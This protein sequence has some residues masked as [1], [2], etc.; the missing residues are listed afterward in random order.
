MQDRILGVAMLDTPPSPSEPSLV[1]SVIHV[2]EAGQRVVVDRVDLLRADLSQ[3]AS[4]ALSSATLIAVGAFLLAGAWFTL[5][6]AAVVGLQQYLSL[7][8]SLTAV[9][10]VTGGLGAG[11][12]VIGIRLGQIGKVGEVSTSVR[13][14]PDE[15]I[16]TNGALRP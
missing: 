4:R 5:M 13:A 8:A 10:A 15:A 2:L 16:V 11:A 9:A 12:I 3:A 1:E 6:G 14:V 7:F